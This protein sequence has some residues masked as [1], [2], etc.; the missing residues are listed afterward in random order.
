MSTFNKEYDGLADSIITNAIVMPAV[1]LKEDGLFPHYHYT[2]NAAWDT[3]A[4]FTF[5]SPRIVDAL[6]L[7]PY[8]ESEIMGIGGDQIAKTYKVHVGL[9]NGFLIHDL[10]V[11][12]SDIDD[13]DVLIGMDIITLTDFCITNKNQK[14]KFSFRIPSEGD[15]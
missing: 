5:I 10:E 6:H 3:G 2:D 9:P 14:T 12:C 11:Y 7:T 13:Y 4:Q 15:F 1:E 8:R